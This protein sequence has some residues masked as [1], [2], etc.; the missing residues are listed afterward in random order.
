MLENVV[1]DGKKRRDAGRFGVQRALDTEI[2]AFRRSSEGVET[3][4][5]SFV[6]TWPRP[7]FGNHVGRSR[8]CRPRCDP[9]VGPTIA[10]R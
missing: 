4:T 3:R 2:K 8:T 7:G 6:A 5:D 9:A 10:A 1:L